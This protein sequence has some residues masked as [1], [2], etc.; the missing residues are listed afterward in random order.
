MSVPTTDMQAMSLGMAAAEAGD[1]MAQAK[2]KEEADAKRW[3]EKIKEAR[4]FDEG[5][6]KQYAFDRRYA[7][8]RKGGGIFEVDVPIAATYIDILKS[9]L[10]A[11]DPDVDV[12]PA[13][14]T[15]PPPEDELVRMAKQAVM[16]DP[17][18][19]Q[20]AQQAAMQARQESAQKKNT[21]VQAVAPAAAKSLQGGA[22]PN[23]LPQLP[24]IDPQ[25]DA[26][27]AARATMDKLV[28][29]KVKE[30]SQPYQ[31]RRD[32]AKQ[33]GSTLEIVISQLW[34][35]G[36]LKVKA[37]P[38]VGSGLTIGIGWLKATWQERTGNDPIV[39]SQ[40]NDLQDN[41]LHLAASRQQLAEGD[42]NPD[43]V[44]ADIERQ[45]L[46]LQAQVEVVVA[47]GLAID[48]VQGEDIQVSP[49]CGAMTSYLDASWIA[50]RSFKTL[51][52]AK[53]CFPKLGD[54]LKSA[55]T[56]G[57]V[58][59]IDPNNAPD[60]AASQDVSETEA[61]SFRAG[62]GS[63]P[64]AEGTSVCVWEAWDK[65]S[66]TIL[67]LVEGI[68]AY[69]RDPY[70]PNPGTSRFYPF[71][72]FVVGEVDGSRHP[73]GPVSRSAPLLDEYDR[74]RSGYAE[75]RRRVKPKTGFDATN[76]SPEE[77]QK[78]EAGGTQEMIPLKPLQPGSPIRDML[79]PLAYA[80]I[81]PA[82]YDTAVI[83]AELEMIWGIQ[84]ALSSSIR[85]AKTATEAEIQQTG[86]TART[87]YMRDNIDS[88]MGELAEYTA[89]VAVQKL[90]AQDVK[91]MAGPWAFWPEGMKIDDIGSLVSVDIRAGSSG[92]PD[93]S[94][95]R[96]AWATV[97]PVLQNAILQV[98]Q[99]RGSSRQ[100]IADS[101]EALIE[102][103]L[104]RT[105]DRLDAARFLPPAPDGDDMPGQ[106]GPMAPGLPA[107]QSAPLPA[108]ADPA[109]I[110]NTEDMTN[111]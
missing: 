66:N 53:A 28:R 81:D 23:Q 82:L 89:E 65:N 58:K 83:R 79:Q 64:I 48:F 92:K 32:D 62:S 10:Y 19:Q 29:A 107:P 60:A 43:E 99:L 94:R 98:G 41:L 74:V 86:T 25:K 87:G 90:D 67:T 51:D 27:A 102:E 109:P 61:D 93:T 44:K 101:I 5:S 69:A 15:E 3:L 47:R 110:D 50:H 105:G 85:T 11:R 39:E 8:R 38:L 73:E 1:Q 21:I 46:G 57:Q 31:Q 35:K 14:S 106:G 18:T 20:Q 2:A 9:F 13:T 37:K 70:T 52:D 96:Q 84:E 26:E 59:P 30:L 12:M 22:L 95:Q 34:K 103:T 36:R 91:D 55:A 80:Q 49:D 68:N 108:P 16:A 111:G 88:L 100:D 7:K 45:I 54:K 63:G 24:D 56:Y 17:T 4:K 97:M 33:F 76:L 40:I 75:H 71:F 42:P 77:I 78:I 6:R 104:A 72:Q